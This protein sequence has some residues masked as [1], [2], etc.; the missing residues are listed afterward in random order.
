MVDREAREIALERIRILFRLA[1]EVF[2]QNPERAQ[3]YVDLAR[4]I[5]MRVR[6]HLPRDLRRRIC[7]RCKGFLVPGVN[8]RVR[9]RQRREPHVAITCLR[10]GAIMRIPLR[11][12]NDGEGA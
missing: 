6:I 9:I 8:C 1:D 5:A 10:C 4:R 3:R 7:R 2:H 12:R 11:R